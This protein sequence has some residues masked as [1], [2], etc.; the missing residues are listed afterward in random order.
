VREAAFE[1]LQD[2]VPYAIVAEVDE[3]RE[4]SDPAYVRIILHVERDSQRG[5]VVG[6]GGRTI[7]ALG[8]AARRRLEGLLG[9]AVYLAL[10]VKVLPKWR[11]NPS[12]L[13]RFGFPHRGSTHE[14][15]S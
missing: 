10:Q 15:G 13:S 11:S 3:F 7:R 4:E 12:I 9:R 14:P 5:I 6:R 8:T 2:E 1:L